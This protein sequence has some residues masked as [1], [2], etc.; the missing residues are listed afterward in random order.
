M[1]AHVKANVSLCIYRAACILI[2]LCSIAVLRA[3]E[4]VFGRSDQADVVIADAA[5]SHMHC[6][7]YRVMNED[8]EPDATWNPTR[9]FDV[10]VEDLSKNGT[11]VKDTKIGKGHKLKI[12]SGT[13]V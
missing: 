10:Y 11:F 2:W 5:V 9:A 8:I 13:E 4:I 12:A 1:L 7:V 3:D 6:R